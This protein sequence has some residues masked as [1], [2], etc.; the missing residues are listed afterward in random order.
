METIPLAP[1]DA[2]T[3][4]RHVAVSDLLPSLSEV[5]VSSIRLS[6]LPDSRRASAVTHS[7]SPNS[8]AASSFGSQTDQP[9]VLAAADSR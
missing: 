4:T 8:T 5:A 2:L 1:V 6:R 9:A 3:V 7:L